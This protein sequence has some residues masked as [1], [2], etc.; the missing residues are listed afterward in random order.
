MMIE[1]VAARWLLTAVFAANQGRKPGGPERRA[2]AIGPWLQVKT[3]AAAGH[4]G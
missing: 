3:Q 2:R 4:A 1:S